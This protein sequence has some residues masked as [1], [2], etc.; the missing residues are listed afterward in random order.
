VYDSQV[1][2]PDSALGTASRCGR[3]LL[4]VG[5]VALMLAGCG[6]PSSQPHEAV[7]HANFPRL[8][9]VRRMGH[10]PWSQYQVPTGTRRVDVYAAHDERA[11][12]VVLLFQGSE[13]YPLFVVHEDGTYRDTSLFQDSISSRLNRC[14]FVR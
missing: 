6:R 3:A 13:C 11:K 2:R 10:G 5:I 7:N 14:H 1:V 12:P 8:E 4:R 9:F